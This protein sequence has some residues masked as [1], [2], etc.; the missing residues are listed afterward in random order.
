[1]SFEAL[2][3]IAAL[4]GVFVALARTAI[5]TDAVLL[6]ALIL[7]TV[8]P[9][10]TAEGLRLGVLSPSEAFSGFGNEGLLTVGL[11]FVL[12]RG[13]DETGGVD[14]IV[15]GLFGRPKTLRG[16]LLRMTFPVVGISAFMNNTPLVAMLIPVVNDWSRKL[17]FSPSKLML[18]LCYAAS[19]GGMC[20]LIGT[21][22]NL[23]VAGMVASRT[24]LPPLEMFDVSW[25]GIPCAI[26]GAVYLV[27][28]APRLLPDRGST[29]GA[30]ADPREYTVEMLVPAD[31]P[32]AGK[33]VEEA[34]LRGLP[35]LFLVEIDR[36]GESI[37]AVGPQQILR[38]GDRLIFAGIVESVRDLQKLRGLIPTTDQVFKLD[39]PRYQRRLFEAVLSNT[40]PL[41][42]MT[43]RDG[44]FRN[45]YNAVV[46][47]V[48]RNGERVR[49]KIGDIEL[50]AGDVL[51][52]EAGQ[53]FAE[54][55]RNSSDFFLVSPL[56]GSVPR[57][58]ER[59]PAALAIIGLMVLAASLGWMSMLA[60]AASAALL[61]V[62]TRCCTVAEARESVE[63][64]V[65]IGI[66]AALGL[67]RAIES[68]GAGALLAEG[69]LSMAGDQ[70]LAALAA[71]FI[72]TCIVTEL[73]TNNAAVALVFPMAQAT[74]DRL[75]VNLT[76]FVMAV[77][78]AGSASFA[79]PF[80]YQTNLMV[81]GPG[82]Y[83]FSDYVR[84]GAP[85]DLLVGATALLV[86]P[87]MWP[88]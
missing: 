30:L 44:R 73:I 51:L 47:A 14:W 81:Y 27:L 63:W 57:R 20:T 3:V 71:I 13:M 65:L 52:I 7:L 58:Y 9:V 19:L 53:D 4:A 62:L 12:V 60:A 2:F 45:R 6:S 66:G 17:R 56:E 22:T 61:I 83:R 79:T 68:S 33:S 39:G 67:G 24:A 78:I 1:M 38:A 16:A 10:W 74:A 75:D 72:V 88:L 32:L 49:A 35:A 8:A 15:H 42:G 31:S 25:V 59:A 43:I 26:V 87:W 28:A 48:A 77:M 34:G 86:I 50:R 41:V 5:P 85:L 69:V 36:E 54:Q 29:M 82:G 46:L 18:P 55:H 70:P 11:L 21:S 64:P 23:V 76:P 84:V 80:G 40:S 37:G